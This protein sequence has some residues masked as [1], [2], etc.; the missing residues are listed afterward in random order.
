MSKFDF[1]ETRWGSLASAIIYL[2]EE[3]SE[4]EL[5]AARVRLQA[6]FDAGDTS[7]ADVLENADKAV[8]RFKAMFE[9]LED[10][11][12]SGGECF[13]WRRGVELGME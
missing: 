7:L 1:V 11:V 6:L 13:G 10:I 3:Q 8:I 2:M 4:A 5:K 12:L 9:G